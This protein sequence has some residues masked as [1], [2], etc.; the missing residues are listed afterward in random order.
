M[1]LPDW[2]PGYEKLLAAAC[3][4]F[5]SLKFLPGTKLQKL[6]MWIAGGSISWFTSEPLA[7]WLKMKE[8][9]IGLIIGI[10]AMAIVSKAMSEMAKTEFATTSDEWVRKLLGL[11]P[12]QHKD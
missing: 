8:G 6:N 3:G 7:T 9:T 10:F 5:A 11:P 12:R 2:N 1:N 4:S